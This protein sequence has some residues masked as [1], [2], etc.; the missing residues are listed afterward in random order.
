MQLVHIAFNA[1]R[2]QMGREV[3]YGRA[4]FCVKECMCKGL[5]RVSIVRHA[6][7]YMNKLEFSVRK[8]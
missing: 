3:G 8:T 5:K 6:L 4:I 2:A 1:L 7:K